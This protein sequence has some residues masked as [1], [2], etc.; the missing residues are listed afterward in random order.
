MTMSPADAARRTAN[1]RLL[2]RQCSSDISDIEVSA[3]HVVLY[4]YKE[5]SWHKSG[6]EGSLFV[7]KHPH[8]FELIVINRSTPDNFQMMLSPKTQLQHQEP[9]LIFKQIT[10]DGSQRIRGIWFHS[11]EERTTV[12]ENLQRLIRHLSQPP[13]TPSRIKSAPEDVAQAAMESLFLSP[14]A[15]TSSAAAASTP[16]TPSQQGVALDKKSLQLAL[17]SLIQDDRFLDLLHSKYLQV[18]R[19][20]IKKQHT[21]SGDG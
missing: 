10:P 13:K 19:A 9:Y 11:D 2:Q 6:I 1:I 5:D 7:A 14:A 17:L 12:F 21:P 20:R 15:S 18:V 16:S 3:T 8:N 4:E